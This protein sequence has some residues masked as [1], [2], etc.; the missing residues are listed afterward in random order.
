MKTRH[1]GPAEGR[2]AS[3]GRGVGG[4]I[5]DAVRKAE[6]ESRRQQRGQALA[7][8]HQ[9]EASGQ[10]KGPCAEQSR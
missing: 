10:G 7:L 9:D 5:E 1:D 2:L 8:A 6:R 4:D 3:D